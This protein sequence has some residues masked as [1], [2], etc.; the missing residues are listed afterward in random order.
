MKHRT[1][2]RGCLPL[3]CLEILQPSNKPC[4]QVEGKWAGGQGDGEGL[5]APNLPVSH[6][7]EVS[8][9]SSKRQAPQGALDWGGVV[10][11]EGKTA[12]V[13]LGVPDP[14]SLQE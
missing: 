12:F 11:A 14:S 2:A 6:W 9:P 13:T 10:G 4:L 5:P 8:R 3:S 1:K 7:M